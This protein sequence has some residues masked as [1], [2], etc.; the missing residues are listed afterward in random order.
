MNKEKS[1]P[2]LLSGTSGL[3]LLVYRELPGFFSPQC[4]TRCKDCVTDRILPTSRCIIRRF[5]RH[6]EALVSDGVRRRSNAS[7]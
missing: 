6:K 7:S 2:M 1:D 3:R 5:A 4:T